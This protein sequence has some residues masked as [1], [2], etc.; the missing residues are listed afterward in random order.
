MYDRNH[1]EALFGRHQAMSVYVTIARFS[2][3]AFTTGEVVKLSSVPRDAC[4]RE[5]NRLTDL[6]FVTRTS[7]RGDYERNDQTRFWELVEALASEWAH[8]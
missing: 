4:S 1:S 8:E 7:R 2:K 5:L 6:G 3:P